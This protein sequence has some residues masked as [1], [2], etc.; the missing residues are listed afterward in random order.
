MKTFRLSMV[1]L[2]TGMMA[3]L[4][5]LAF[6]E[7]S[8]P[9]AKPEMPEETAVLLE[10]L[11][12]EKEAIHEEITALMD[13]N[14]EATR[15]ERKVLIDEWRAANQSRIEAQKALL[16]EIRESLGSEFKGALRDKMQRKRDMREHMREKLKDMTPEERQQAKRAMKQKIK[17]RSH[18]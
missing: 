15:E 9:P 2:L 16:A 4:G 3:L 7:N 14:P 6:A 10:T 8:A 18:R 13:A 11:R 5:S 12:S 17:N 1:M